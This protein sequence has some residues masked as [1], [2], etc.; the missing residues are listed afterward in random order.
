MN[1]NHKTHK[2][3]TPDEIIEKKKDFFYPNTM[4]FYKNP[5]HIVKGEMQYLFDNQGKRYTDFYAGV[6]VLN[7]GHSNPEILKAVT[8]QLHKLQ[9]TSIIYLTQ[10]MVELAEELAKVL[11]GNIQNTF[12]C[13]SGTEANEG[14]L[15]LARMHTKKKAFLSLE[16]GLHGRSFLTMSVTGIPMWRIDPFL[17]QDVYFAKCFVQEGMSPNE[18]AEKSLESIDA[19][20]VDKGNTIAACIIE[21]IQGNGGINTPPPD[22]FVKLKK[23]LEDYGILLIV[24]EVQTGFARTGTF[25]AIE[26]FGVIPDI[27]TY[28]KALGNGLPIGAFS[29]RPEVAISF[30]KPSAST[31]GGNPISTTAGL[32]VLDYIQSHQLC[33]RSRELGEILKNSLLQLKEK[34]PLIQEVRGLGLM[35]GLV[36]SAS[37]GGQIVDIIMEEMKDRG[38]IIGKSGMDRNVLAFQ[39]PLVIEVQ[40]IQL[41]LEQLDKVLAELN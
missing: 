26:Q 23:R 34:Y 7:C 32:A 13:N 41:M 8:D 38:F 3:M 11:P 25:F 15:L 39:P 16:G 21:P 6:T 30:N 2:V 27:I 28:A 20:L 4:H 24:D 37:E 17:D 18:A 5:P 19:I 22:F 35:L 36:F 12:F 31:L 40:D 33:K 14:A 29:A 10:P 1:E 9:H